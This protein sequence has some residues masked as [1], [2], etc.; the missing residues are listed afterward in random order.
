[1]R[2]VPRRVVCYYKF[3]VKSGSKKMRE[4]GLDI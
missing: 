2:I 4:G 3:N 1:M